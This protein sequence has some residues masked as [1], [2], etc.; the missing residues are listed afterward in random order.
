MFNIK[1]D[2]MFPNL[3]F[4]ILNDDCL[5]QFNEITFNIPCVLEDDNSLKTIIKDKTEEVPELVQSARTLIKKNGANLC[6]DGVGGTYFIK[7]LNGKIE[8]VFKPIDEEP[9]AV[10]N[11]KD[12]LD[13]PLLPPGGGAKREIAAFLLDRGHAGVPETYYVSKVKSPAF[14]GG[15][16][17]KEGSLQKYIENIGNA[18]TLGTSLFPTQDVHNIGILDLRLLNLDRNEENILLIKQGENLRL[19]PIDHTYSLPSTLDNLYFEWMHWKQAKVPFSPETLSYIQSLDPIA[20]AI[21]LRK[22]G[23]EEEAI[24]NMI[25]STF[26]L[27]KAALEGKNLYE[28]ASMICRKKLSQPSALEEVVMKVSEQDKKIEDRLVLFQ[29]MIETTIKSQSN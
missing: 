13:D 2:L 24:N 16:L 19:V 22:L 8:S 4:A 1:I 25:Y 3:G 11:P 28:I 10:N 9:G 20:D 17:E 21:I 15:D 12:L 26:F 5:L 6:P 7:G 27:K 29:K 18:S 14:H 23:I